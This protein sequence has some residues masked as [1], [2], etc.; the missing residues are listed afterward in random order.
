MW[1]A[2]CLSSY[3]FKAASPTLAHFEQ[4]LRGID[5]QRWYLWLCYS[6]LYVVGCF[7]T[8]QKDTNGV[9]T[10]KIIPNQQS[11]HM[12][13][14]VSKTAAKSI[15]HHT[16]FL[17]H[18][19]IIFFYD[20]NQLISLYPLICKYALKCDLITSFFVYSVSLNKLRCG[21]YHGNVKPMK[22]TGDYLSI[23]SR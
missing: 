8:L 9:V 4:F 7:L 10:L 20:H 12:A 17:L 11:R 3:S 21:V 22:D 16:F 23:N 18:F 14:E 5:T 13:C 19:I 6:L 15:S 2:C 1:F